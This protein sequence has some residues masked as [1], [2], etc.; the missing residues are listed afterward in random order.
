MFAISIALILS[1]LVARSSVLTK[2]DEVK[3]TAGTAIT[4]RPAGTMGG[5]GGGDPLTA[6]QLSTIQSTAHISATTM[7]LTDQ[8]SG[9]DTE[10]ES[11]LEFGGFGARQRM[12]SGNSE[13]ATSDTAVQ[14]PTPTP[15]I[16]LTGTNEVDSVSTDGGALNITSGATIDG[17][18]RSAVALIGSTLAEK[19]SLEVGDTFTAYD[20]TITVQGIYETGNQFQD[21]GII[22]PLITL[23]TITDQ[24]D[25]VTSVIAT[26]DSSDNVASTVTA[27]ESSL[28]DDADITSE[29]ERAQESVSSLEG[30]ASLAL[31][32]VIA[33]AI[34]GAAIVLLAMVMVVRERRREIGVMKA[35]GGTDGKV[36]G[37]FITEGLTLTVFGTVIGMV[38]GILVSGPMTT[39]LVSSQNSTSNSTTQQAGNPPSTTGTGRPQGG[40]GGGFAQLS[41]NATQVTASL[42]PDIIAIALGVTLFISLIGTA[43]PAWFTARV[44][45]AEVLRTE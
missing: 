1:M 38:L 30:I 24:A 23:Q 8:L 41:T 5:F 16:T 29:V 19:N 21:S 9:D 13:T 42:S 40:P 2:I 4:I 20:T 36:V 43:I 33:A 32:G 12:M 45:P 31:A 27:L 17:S 28:G 7:T 18:S 10:L 15:S 34:A 6:E 11:S 37:Q 44:R 25:I 39:S 3:A 35:I 26:V 22:L 14:M